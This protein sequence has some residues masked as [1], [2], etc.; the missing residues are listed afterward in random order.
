M[1]P[2]VKRY[3]GK[4]MGTF[5][6]TENQQKAY[7]E[8]DTA[9]EGK[10]KKCSVT[11]GRRGLEA[12]GLHPRFLV[13]VVLPR[14]AQAVL[15]MA[16]FSGQGPHQA[17]PGGEGFRLQA[18]GFVLKSQGCV[19]PL[20]AGGLESGHHV[21]KDEGVEGVVVNKKGVANV[22]AEDVNGE[23][24]VKGGA[25]EKMGDKVVAIRLDLELGFLY[26]P[27]GHALVDVPVGGVDGDVADAIAALFEK[28]AKA[29]ALVGGVALFKEGVAE[30]K[31]LVVIG[32]DDFFVFQEIDGEVRVRRGA[33]IIEVRIGMV[34]DFVA[35]LVPGG[36]KLGAFGLVDT[37]AADEERGSNVSAVESFQDAG[38]GVRPSEIG[39]ELQIRVVHGDSELGARGVCVARRRG[40]LVRGER[41]KR[42]DEE[43]STR[44]GGC[45]LKSVGDEFA[46]MHSH[47]LNKENLASYGRE[48]R[49]MSGMK[50]RLGERI[51]RVRR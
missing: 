37:H 28:R 9:G 32:S 10:V 7:L 36:E 42:V 15:K 13:N 40:A 2:K 27:I 23:L 25:V 20:P 11:S 26:E 3:K 21:G 29:V 50:M 34:A 14:V 22:A 41:V 19:D 30:E 5:S 12:E 1:C 35:G 16:G 46:A 33:A 24:A 38:V 18:E 51:R 4:E 8:G 31:S 44:D 17:L 47:N 48:R 45:G 43:R 39:V 6:G 49:S